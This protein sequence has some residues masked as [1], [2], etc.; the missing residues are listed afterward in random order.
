[1]PG[2][3]AFDR[4]AAAAHP[5]HTCVIHANAP[6]DASILP[7]RL[8]ALGPSVVRAKGLL[9]DPVAPQRWWLVQKVGDHIELKNVSAE[10]AGRGDSAIVLLSL[11]P[12]PDADD[13][14]GSLGL[15]AGDHPP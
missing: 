7:E 9:R 3:S 13:L 15:V 12:L 11:E 4:H 1:M 10:A 8:R 5:F 2:A 6:Q 14:A